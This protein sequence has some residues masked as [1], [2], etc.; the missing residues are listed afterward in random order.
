MAGISSPTKVDLEKC[1]KMQKGEQERFGLIRRELMGFFM[2][3]WRKGQEVL[4][5]FLAG[6]APPLPAM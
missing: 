5:P 6:A 4:G 2:F 3:S 1:K